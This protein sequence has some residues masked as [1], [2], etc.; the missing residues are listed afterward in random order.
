MLSVAPVFELLAPYSSSQP[1]SVSVTL[2]SSLAT[3]PLPPRAIIALPATMHTVSQGMAAVDQ[4][5][6]MHSTGELQVPAGRLGPPSSPKQIQR[7]LLPYFKIL[8][9]SSLCT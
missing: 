7:S 6:L 5:K 1:C 4:Q 3:F 8:T 9:V 2:L